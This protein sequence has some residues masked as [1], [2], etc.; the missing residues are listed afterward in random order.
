MRWQARCRADTE[1]TARTGWV[2]IRSASRSSFL[3]EHDLF[4]K[5]DSTFPDH[6]LAVMHRIASERYARFRTR[7]TANRL[8]RVLARVFEKSLVE[9]GVNLPQLCDRCFDTAFLLLEHFD[10]FHALLACEVQAAVLG[11]VQ[12]MFDLRKSE[13]QPPPRQDDAQTLAVAGPIE[14]RGAV[15]VRIEEAFRFVEAQGAERDAV[16]LR[17]LSD[18]QSP[19]TVGVAWRT[20]FLRVV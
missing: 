2:V 15:A 16:F 3:F 4:G 5:P 10:L 18:G 11:P 17:D 8:V 20:F 9:R 7:R 6:A 12:Q 13:P 1:R 14:P 19:I